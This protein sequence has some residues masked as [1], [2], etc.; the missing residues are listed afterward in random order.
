MAPKRKY[1]KKNTTASQR[2][3]DDAATEG[4]TQA[5]AAATANVAATPSNTSDADVRG[6]IQL[7]TQILA[8]QAQRH[9]T[10]PSSGASSG[11]NI[12]VR[13]FVL[14]LKPELHRDANTVAQNDKMTISKI[15]AFVQGNE[16][17]MIE[18]E[19]LQ[20]QKDR[21]F[22]KRAKSAGN[23][24]HGGSQGDGN[25]QFFKN[26]SSRPTPLTASAPFQRSKFNQK[27]RNF[28]TTDSHSQ[29]S[30]TNRGFQHHTCNTCGKKHSGVCRLGMNGCFG[31]GQPG[32]FLPDCPSARRNTEGNNNVAQS[33]NS[34]TPR[35]FQAQQGR[36]AAKPGNTGGGQN[37]L[38]A[39]TGRQDTEARA[40][41][42]TGTLTVF[43][44]DV[45]P[46]KL[47]EPFEVSTP[48]G[49]SLTVRHMYRVVRFEFPN[50]PIIEWKG[51]SVVPRGRFISYLKARKMISKDY[52][53]LN[54]VTIK[55]RYPLPRIDDLFD[56]RQGAQC[57]SKIDL[58]TGYHQL[59]V[60]EVDIPKT[61]FRTR[62][63]H[64]EFLVMSFGLTNAPAAFMDLMNR[65]FKPYLDLFVIVFIDDI[66]V[67]SRNEAEHAEHL[68][69]VLQ[70]LKDC[71]LFAKFSK[72]EFWLKSVAFL[73]HVISG[74]G[75]K[76][77][78][79]KIDAVKSWPR[80]T[81]V[82]EIR[83]FLGLAGY[84]RRFVEGFS[85]IS[86]PL[87]KLTRK[88]IK[89]QWSDAC[90][91]S[92][93][94]LKKRLTSAPVLTLPEGTE[95]FVVY[96]NVIADALSR[97]SMGSLAHV[98]VDKRIM[99]KEGSWDD[100]L[101]LIEF[102]Y[103]NSYHASIGMAPFEA[104]Y[105]RRCRSPIGWFEV[106]EAELLGPDLVYQAMEKVKLIQKR[107]KK[108]Q[109]LFRAAITPRLVVNLEEIPW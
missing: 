21:E 56:Q 20:K 7:L 69:I 12:M 16:T 93:E 104:L 109:S 37:R 41:V 98:E 44:F 97:H 108:A 99:T 59:K 96:S 64:F 71:E 87:T 60:K 8:N 9:E 105:G 74:E 28:G 6:A 24:S 13:R 50:E 42:V 58:R 26:R 52:R 89:F 103:N 66:L 107:L 65:V 32:H 85:S 15:L 11:S 81:S 82:T 27:D 88:K 67:Y 106:G 23:F 101:P 3:T 33:S 35:N 62:Y 18:E 43:T 45:E 54:K 76:V 77:D 38:Y 10:A 47:C 102:S 55:N 75:V 84:Y 30:V 46:E 1:I 90:E 49:E 17:R 73:G 22:S 34:A 92:F 39:L 4:G 29:A 57:Y 68:R 95:G 86:A 79:Q 53:Q 5:Q 78:S 63:G 94:E 80:P 51:N 14:G 40:D 100:H 83:S 2:V 36:G 70:T 48:V 91:R 25:R 19:A 61:A 72:C 31:C